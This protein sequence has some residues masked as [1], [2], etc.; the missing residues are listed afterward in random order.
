MRDS[1]KYIEPIYTNAQRDDFKWDL[2]QPEYKMDDRFDDVNHNRDVMYE[3]TESRYATE[4]V[5]VP[6]DNVTIDPIDKSKIKVKFDGGA[7]TGN[8]LH[9]DSSLSIFKDGKKMAIAIM[10][11]VLN[12][13]TG[14]E[15]FGG[16]EISIDEHHTIKVEGVTQEVTPEDITI[17]EFPVFVKADGGEYAPA[18]LSI[19]GDKLIF[20]YGE[21]STSVRVLA[22]GRFDSEK[23][24]TGMH[25]GEC[26]LQMKTYYFQP[27]R[28]SMG[29]TWTDMTELYLDLSFGVSAEDT[30]IDS[31]GQEIK[32]ALD[33]QAVEYANR[34][35]KVRSGNK[36]VQFDAEAGQLDAEGGKVA[37]KD[38]Y[39]HTAQTFTQA[40]GHVSDEMLNTFNRGGVTAIVGGPKACRYLELI[41]GYTTKGAQPSIGGHQ[42]GELNGVP[43]FK[44]PSSVIAD[45]ELLTT[46]KNEQAEGD[47][48]I[49]I[50]TLVPFAST[51]KLPRKN[52][53]FE[54]GIARYE[55]M[56]AL[57]PRYLGRVLIKNIR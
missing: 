6:A 11:P 47:V 43:V 17:A 28:I 19:D 1:I 14:A 21:T 15:W 45:D 30:L 53:Y 5:N 36:L 4:L 37:I 50:G 10:G 44:V 55:D 52:F 32:K 41:E 20:S 51:G 12:D 35:Q 22:V 24:L 29:V 25:L 54:Q 9:R 33:F 18:T 49:A 56:Q 2:E 13:S 23:D 34:V 46:W 38:S 8:Y 26:E 39:W 42:V 7:L 57:Q 3:S 40:L 27:R 31:V 48:S 16:K